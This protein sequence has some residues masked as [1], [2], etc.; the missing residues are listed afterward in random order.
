MLIKNNYLSG[1]QIKHVLLIM[2][3]VGLVFNMEIDYVD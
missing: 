1:S 2:N 3:G